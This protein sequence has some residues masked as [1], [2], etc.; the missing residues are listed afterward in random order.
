MSKLKDLIDENDCLLLSLLIL[1]H[2]ENAVLASTENNNMTLGPIW[3]ALEAL[4]T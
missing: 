2:C 4:Y 3:E 1:A